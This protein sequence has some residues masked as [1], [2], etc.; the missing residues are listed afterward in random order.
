MY[1][2][3]GNTNNIELLEEKHYTII[4]DEEFE[5]KFRIGISKSKKYLVIQALY[6]EDM[7]NLIFDYFQT[8]LTLKNLKEKS[9]TF[10]AIFSMDDAF[11]I[12]NNNFEEKKVEVKDVAQ[13]KYLKL[14]FNFELKPLE[15]NLLYKNIENDLLCKYF[16]I[17]ESIFL[18]NEE[19]EENKEENDDENNINENQEIQENKNLEDNEQIN[20]NLDNKNNLEDKEK[21]N[22]ETNSKKEEDIPNI[23]TNE[24]IQDNEK[25]EENEEIN[26]EQQENNIEEEKENIED[27]KNE[28]D[29]IENL[30]SDKEDYEEN[31]ENNN[32]DEDINNN[33]VKNDNDNEGNNIEDNNEMIIKKNEEIEINK[34]N[35]ENQDDSEN[36]QNNENEIDFTENKN[37]NNNNNISNDNKPY[38][39]IDINNEEEKN[40]ESIN[41]NN[42]EI[43]DNNKINE[44]LLNKIK[45]LENENISLKEEINNLKKEVINYQ[46]EI[47]NLKKEDENNQ[48]EIKNLKNENSV[49]KKINSELKKE[50]D[51]HKDKLL[52][53]NLT[54]TKLK[55]SIKEKESLKIELQKLRKEMKIPEQKVSPNKKKESLNEI[56]NNKPIKTIHE[57]KEININNDKKVENKIE[58]K[59]IPEN[60]INFESKSPIN[61]KVFKT[62]SQ[63]SYILYTLDK[64]FEAFTTLSGEILLVYATKFKSLE[65]FD[66]VKQKFQKTVLN[67][68]N[69]LILIIRHYCPKYLNKDLILSGSNNP[70]YCIKIWELPNWVC[71]YNLSKVYET[72]NML[73]AC[74]HF[75][76]Y[77]KESFIFASNDYGDIKLFDMNEKFI[78]NINKTENNETFFLDTYYDDTELRYFLISGEMKCV[79]AYE[80]NTHQLVRTYID[81]NSFAEHLSAFLYKNHDVT[82]LVECEF[83][84]YIRIWNFHSGNL[85]KKI[86]ICKR[87][88]LVSMCLWNKN[89][90]FVSCVDYTIKLVDFKNYNFIK[91]FH[92]H[93]NEV[94]TLK[95]IIHPNH[96]E[97]LLSQGL[98]NEQIKMWINA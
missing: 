29:N 14:S 11:N 33:N 10:S 67:A 1:K 43:K 68:H 35:E 23:P 16:Q 95:K 80:L 71:I 73:A 79:K 74:I 20:I 86:E 58:N 70:D 38:E 26:D 76:E 41:N 54:E 50:S 53:A 30:Y 42:D 62:L 40:N 96:G 47:S 78:K 81:T 92:G 2:T 89:Y 72:G 52:K 8:K 22:N 39:I 37:T 64:T 77:Q 36:E 13:M 25:N 24:E 56:I 82:E 49:L 12:V 85:I 6:E 98:C 93:N 9:R 61:L 18:N 45:L 31:N 90:L 32:N 97:C 44:E 19:D 91:S 34:K 83:Y 4:Y 63:S 15:I 51:K 87:T 21:E 66:L 7:E 55:K 28:E 84:G 46:K 60:N 88:P 65:C 48:N 57:E 59:I 69:S 17:D 3:L 94:C 75:D 27:K 5:V